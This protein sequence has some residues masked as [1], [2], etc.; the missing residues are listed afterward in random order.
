[1]QYPVTPCRS[2]K[3][4]IIWAKTNSGKN[5]PL[6]AEPCTDG[7]ICIKDGLAVVVSDKQGGVWPLPFYK[8][9]FATC[10]NAKQHRRPKES[11]DAQPG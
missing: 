2:C 3:A 10:P 7:N 8:S 11:T 5:I 9:H 1:M 4:P 6:D